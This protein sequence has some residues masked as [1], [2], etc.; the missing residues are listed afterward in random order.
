M[1]VAEKLKPEI[2]PPD[3]A[4]YVK[5][6]VHKEKPPV[7]E[8]WWWV[9]GASILRKIYLKGPLGT[10]RLASEY[11]GKEDRGRKP[12]R[13]VKGSRSIVRHLL[14]QLTELGYLEK[15]P[16]GRKLTKRGRELLE[17]SAK[18]IDHGR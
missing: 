12:Y 1:H 16:K 14:Q 17:S 13:A 2:V 18:E 3:W 5:T 7:Q 4:G 11:G 10:E 6:G 8:D 15:S 9:R